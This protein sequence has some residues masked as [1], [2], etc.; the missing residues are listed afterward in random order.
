L[1]SFVNM[2]DYISGSI[3]DID[4]A[5]DAPDS[6]SLLNDV[7]SVNT[8]LMSNNSPRAAARSALN[9]LSPSFRRSN[10]SIPPLNHDL[11]TY[12]PRERCNSEQDKADEISAQ[13][14]T[15]PGSDSGMRKSS[16]DSFSEPMVDGNVDNT[17]Y[18]TD[19]RESVNAQ[20]KPRVVWLC[21]CIPFPLFWNYRP[22]W[23]KYAAV[24]VRNAPCFWFCFPKLEVGATD[25]NVVYRLN[26]LCAILALVEIGLAGY[27]AYML[28]WPS[29]RSLDTD[30]SD[31]DNNYRMTL[32][33]WSTNTFAIFAGILAC[34]III[35]EIATLPLI[36]EVNLNGSMMLHWALGW[37]LPLQVAFGLGLF[38]AFESNEVW[39]KH[40]WSTPAMALYR[41]QYCQQGTHNSR[42]VVP[43]GG[44]E[45]RTEEEWC[46]DN[47][48]MTDCTQ[49]RDS[50]QEGMLIYAN[51]FFSSFGVICLLLMMLL[52]L[53]RIVLTDIISTPIIERNRKSNITFWLAFPIILSFT[54]AGILFSSPPF[55]PDYAVS[56]MAVQI[57]LALFALYYTICGSFF[58]ISTLLALFA[59]TYDVNTAG[60][61]KIKNVAAICFI[62]LS[63]IN[64]IF[65]TFILVEGIL[66]ATVF[67]GRDVNDEVRGDIACLGDPIDSCTCCDSCSSCDC[68]RRFPEWTSADVTN[69]LQSQKKF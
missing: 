63:V 23:T 24:L 57:H 53:T 31:E 59:G 56:G 11:V 10:L 30:I 20:R 7:G 45:S 18:G 38:D 19:N 6:S 47:F 64:V 55:H 8:S 16:E 35:V 39:I 60:D 49:I 52:W 2:E 34:V 12:I 21:R 9:I 62:I 66:V 29:D 27:H 61:K 65:I 37:F 50:A 46:L 51:A 54:V 44:G 1:F 40:S 48:N 43:I 42:C 25:R 32:N 17:N 4:A 33:L 69:M 15:M 67:I 14:G 3:H 13:P 68:P 58:I 41:M 5:P 26:L 36:R 22:K 28:F